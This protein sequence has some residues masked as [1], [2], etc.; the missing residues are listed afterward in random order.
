MKSC[1]RG[2]HQQIRQINRTILEPSNTWLKSFHHR[3][4]AVVTSA[5][6]SSPS[7]NDDRKALQQEILDEAKALTLSLYRR[8]VR[9]AYV[10]RHANENDEREFSEREKKRLRDLETRDARLTM[11][12]MLPPV[13]REDELRSRFEYYLSYARENFVQEADC[14]GDD[15]DQRHIDRYLH[16]LRRGEEQ[17]RWLLQDMKFGDPYGNTFDHGRVKSFEKKVRSYLNESDKPVGGVKSAQGTE[18]TTDTD[19]D[20]F[21]DDADEEEDDPQAPGWYKNPRSEG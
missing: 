7:L 11:L 18:G 3:T 12:S 21:W 14:L 16:H 1:I 9:S 19:D 13:D 20:S 4:L 15:M 8:C 17:R 6:L 2:V 10:I 5:N